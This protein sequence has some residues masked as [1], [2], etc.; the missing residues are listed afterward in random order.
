M[1]N[2]HGIEFNSSQS[3]LVKDIVRE[4]LKDGQCSVYA[5]PHMKPDGELRM[6]SIPSEP[7]PRRQHGVFLRI[8]PGAKEATIVRPMNAKAGEQLTKLTKFSQAELLEL[9]R[10]W[11]K[12]TMPA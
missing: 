4:L 6:A 2:V 11:R 8:R 10:T 7:G 12:Q 1:P 9:I 5:V 3:E